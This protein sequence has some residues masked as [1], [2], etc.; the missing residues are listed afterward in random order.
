MY[1]P[2]INSIKVAKN[3]LWAPSGT[4]QKTKT[5]QQQNNPLANKGNFGRLLLTDHAYYQQ[6][7]TICKQIGVHL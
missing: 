3:N 1:T 7:I 6:Y 5:K 2:L 4:P